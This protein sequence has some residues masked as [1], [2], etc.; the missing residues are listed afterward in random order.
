MFREAMLT[1]DEKWSKGGLFTT[2]RKEVI[3]ISKIK[4]R[5]AK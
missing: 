5:E 2:K 1:D 4:L 3:G